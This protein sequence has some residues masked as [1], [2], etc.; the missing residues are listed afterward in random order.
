MAAWCSQI[1]L[2]KPVGMEDQAKQMLQA[3]SPLAALQLATMAAAAGESWTD[4]A[5]AEIG[6]A[7][8]H[9]TLLASASCSLS[10]Q[11]IL[12]CRTRTGS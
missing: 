9:G 11:Q 1:W 6:Y 4:G 5:F 7:L 2:Y 12:H 3:H 8:L 10:L